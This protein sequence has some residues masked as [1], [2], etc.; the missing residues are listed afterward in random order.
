MARHFLIIAVHLLRLSFFQQNPRW[1]PERCIEAMS[2]FGEVQKDDVR[3]PSADSMCTFSIRDRVP[4]LYP[5]TLTLGGWLA[6]INSPTVGFHLRCA[7]GTRAGAGHI[8]APNSLPRRET[9]EKYTV[10]AP[11]AGPG[12][13]AVS[14]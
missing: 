2:T 12:V 14:G 1:K 10:L 9:C 7:L 4:I 11:A 13:G 8:T 5:E 6:R 3:A